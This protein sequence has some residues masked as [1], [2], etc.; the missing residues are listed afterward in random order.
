MY[1]SVTKPYY[2]DSCEILAYNTDRSAITVAAIKSNNLARISINGSVYLKSVLCQ[3]IVAIEAS[4]KVWASCSVVFE[5]GFA[6]S[7]LP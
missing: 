2:F 7:G 5:P 1:E 3:L 4:E 6:T